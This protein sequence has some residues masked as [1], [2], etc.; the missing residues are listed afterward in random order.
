MK[1]Q[2][3]QMRRCDQLLKIKEDIIQNFEWDKANAT[4]HQRTP[5]STNTDEP[6]LL[7]KPFAQNINPP[8]PK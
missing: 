2:E 5:P 6:N 1:H 7:Q 8:G 4:S 3:D